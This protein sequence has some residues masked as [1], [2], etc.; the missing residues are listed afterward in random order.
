ML[1]SANPFMWV[2]WGSPEKSTPMARPVLD[3]LKD[4][5]TDNYGWALACCEWH[6]EMAEDVLQEAYLR[7]LDGRAE[8]AEKSTDKTWFFAVIKRVAAEW[9]GKQ[10]RR[11]F[12]FLRHHNAEV[13][14]ADPV[15]EVKSPPAALMQHESSREL[16]EAL[17]QLS[18]R[19]REV[20]HLVFYSELSLGQ[21]AEALD[22]SLGS[23]RTHYHRGK[24]KLAELLQV[25]GSDE[26]AG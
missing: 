4:R 22:I 19:Q 3:R 24:I 8:F 9:Q 10:R 23:A 20:L 7:V 12:L 6:R 15:A 2:K 25:G 16:R 21:A 13:P 26:Q 11:S 18:T 17:L 14:I 5:H 1:L